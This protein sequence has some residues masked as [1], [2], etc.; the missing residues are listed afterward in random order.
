M[1]KAKILIVED[2]AITSMDMQH[3]FKLWGYELCEQVSSADDAIKKAEQYKPDVVIMDINLDGNTN[4]IAAA[5]HIHY[6]LGI[7][8]IF[9]TGYSD[10]ETREKAKIADPAGYFIKPLDFNKIRLP[11]DSVVKTNRI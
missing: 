2:E 9:I 10:K 4:G 8:V 5:R 6:S 1:Y 7:P 11:I 3:I